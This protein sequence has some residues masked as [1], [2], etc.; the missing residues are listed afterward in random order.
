MTKLDRPIVHAVPARRFDRHGLPFVVFHDPHSGRTSPFLVPLGSDIHVRRHGDGQN[1]LAE[2]P[3]RVQS[4]TGRRRIALAH[5]RLVDLFNDH[6][7]LNPRR[8]SCASST[9]IVF[10]SLD[11]SRGLELSS[12]NGHAI[13]G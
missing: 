11:G 12:T 13:F 5:E 3:L 4:G 8:A 7:E 9:K 1:T 6:F 10:H 2:I